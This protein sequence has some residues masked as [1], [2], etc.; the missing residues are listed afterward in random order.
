MRLLRRVRGFFASRERVA[1]GVFPRQVRAFDRAYTIVG[2]FYACNVFIVFQYM[3]RWRGLAEIRQID[4]LWPVFWV[5]W[6]GIE[7]AVHGIMATVVVG[8]LAAAFLPHRRAARTSA[9]LGLLLYHAFINS[10]GKIGHNWHAWILCALLLVFLPDGTRLQ[11]APSRAQRQRYLNV[12]WGAQAMQL[13]L[14]SMAGIQKIAGVVPQALRGQV[15]SFAPEALSY[16][17]ASPDTDRQ[18]K[19]PG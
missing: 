16:H 12:F 8:A 2:L 4:P 9:F 3:H 1:S 13:V 10:F 17:I 15:H 14:Y 6:L 5:P 18:R 11:L 19:H 7:T